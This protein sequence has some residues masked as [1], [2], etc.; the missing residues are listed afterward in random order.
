MSAPPSPS[1]DGALSARHS[2]PAAL[3]GLV[4]GLLVLRLALAAALPLTEDEA[5][6]RL[7][8]EAPAWG[9][10]D[11]PP[12]IAWWIWL[13]ERVAGDTALGVR[14]LPAVASALTSLLVFDLARLAEASPAECRRAVIWYNATLLAA[15]GGFLAVPDAPAALFWVVSLWAAFKALKGGG[16]RCWLIVGAAGGLAALSKYS[17]LFLGPGIFVW[18]LSTRDGRR[19]LTTPGPWLALIVGVALFGGNVLWNA[20][21]QWLTFHKQFGRI[22]PHRFAPRYLLEFVATEALLLNPLVAA[23][24]IRLIGDRP[25]RHPAQPSAA[26]FLI[27]SAPFLAYL[28][29]HS[30]HD[31]IQAHWP[32]PVFPSLAI[33]AAFSASTARGVWVYLRRATPFVGLAACGLALGYVCLP[34][35]GAPLRWDPA[36][37][38]RDWPRFTRR[39]ETLRRIDG[40]GWIGTTSYGLASQLMAN[41]TLH[42]PILQI[43]ERDRWQG[44]RHGVSVDARQS[45]L[46]V[47]LTRRIDPAALRRCFAHVEPLGVIVRGA[48]GETGK[49]Y[50]AFLVNG[51]A[52]DLLR[53]GCPLARE[54]PEPTH[55]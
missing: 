7:W 22:A 5:Y 49:A 26:P 19:A 42:A 31:R 37:P 34:L 46:I 2:P 11:H 45:G 15:A 23:F 44:L 27:T 32:A 53:D 33:A 41:R 35:A 6:Y 12:M 10:F 18:F 29:I 9:Y 4:L 13:G 54:A 43:S 50:A 8:A 28:V 51:P 38:L 3:S 14:L 30:L 55:S 17:A 24:L 25:P 1:G 47:D 16:W 48:A 20:N 52:G 39:L 21:H 40:A 36:T